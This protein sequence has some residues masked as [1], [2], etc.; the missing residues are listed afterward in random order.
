MN[1]MQYSHA[2][3]AVTARAIWL[4]CTLVSRQVL[5]WMPDPAPERDSK[6]AQPLPLRLSPCSRPRHL[7]QER[8]AQYEQG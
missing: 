4:R 6:S 3:H 2:S 7:Q 8:N 5:F 1:K